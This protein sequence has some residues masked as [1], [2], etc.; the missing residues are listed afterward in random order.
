[1]NQKDI[2]AQ[3]QQ[4]PAAEKLPRRLR[5]LH[6]VWPDRNGNISYLLTLC[7]EGR[8]HVL[9]NQTIFDR[10]VSFL[11]DSPTRYMWWGRR[12]VIMP[13]HIHVIAHQGANANTLANGSKP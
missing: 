10:F 11:L 13:D 7:I 4:L 1:M 2:H 3:K 12:F 6:R 9:N 8:L 5:R